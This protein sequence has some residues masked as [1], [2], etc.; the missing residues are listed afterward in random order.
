MSGLTRFTGISLFVLRLFFILVLH[1]F[2]VIEK[3]SAQYQVDENS[4]NS[5]SF[6][7][8]YK[9]ISIYL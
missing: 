6:M 7:T 1:N 8:L 4:I 3:K 2:T 9:Y 5:Y